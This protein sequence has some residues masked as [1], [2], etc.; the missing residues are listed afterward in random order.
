MHLVNIALARRLAAD[1]VD[2]RTAG[3]LDRTIR[4]PQARSGAGGAARTG[5]CIGVIDTERFRFLPSELSTASERIRPARVLSVP[6]RQ[7]LCLAFLAAGAMR[8]LRKHSCR[9]LW[10]SGPVR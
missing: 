9:L 1:Q 6:F 5:G 10:G 2:R 3:Q 7:P 4:L 8:L